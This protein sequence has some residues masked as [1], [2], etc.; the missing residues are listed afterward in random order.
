M[1]NFKCRFWASGETFADNELPIEA[2]RL[3]QNV[4]RGDNGLFNI[5]PGYKKLPV[6][7]SPGGRIMGIGHFKTVAGLDRQ[8]AANR[9]SVWQFD[10]TTWV[11]ITGTPLTGTDYD[12]VRFTT[13]YEAG[14]YK[15][16]ITN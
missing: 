9:T 1:F 2:L 3:S 7:F 13:F 11:D 4:F 14:V 5:R 6:D 16:I 8:I 10:G 15:T 12:H